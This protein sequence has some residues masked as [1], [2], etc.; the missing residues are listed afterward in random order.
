MAASEMEQV[1]THILR[2]LWPELQR[3]VRAIIDGAEIGAG[4]GDWS[5]V[6]YSLIVSYTIITSSRKPDGVV[7]D[8]GPTV[9]Y[10]QFSL[11]RNNDLCYILIMIKWH[12]W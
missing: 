6:S 3:T 7:W 12:R 11:Y 8:T 10:V 1:K 5:A 9:K 2:S 4:Q